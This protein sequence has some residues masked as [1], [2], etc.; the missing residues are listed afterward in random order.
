MAQRGLVAEIS[1]VQTNSLTL[2]TGSVIA[3]V[4]IKLLWTQFRSLYLFHQPLLSVS[5]EYTC[6]ISSAV[7][8]NA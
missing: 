7:A 5:G 4:I 8:E 3:R 6:S 2:T 1:E